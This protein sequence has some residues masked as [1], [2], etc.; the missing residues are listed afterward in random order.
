MLGFSISFL[1]ENIWQK[2]EETAFDHLHLLLTYCIFFREILQI[3]S[4]V[5]I[6]QKAIKTNSSSS[7]NTSNFP[8]FHIKN[9]LTFAYYGITFWDFN[10]L[11]D[12]TKTWK[13]LKVKTKF[14][15]KMFKYRN[16]VYCDFKARFV[17]IFSNNYRH[18]LVLEIL[19]PSHIFPKISK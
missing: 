17:I 10:S 15:K 9:R 1:F 13:V 3:D 19:L 16:T 18:C 6:C 11:Q 2:Y 14:L 12:V 5:N 8:L 4:I 7:P